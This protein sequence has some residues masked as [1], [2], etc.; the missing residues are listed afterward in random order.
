MEFLLHST[1][2]TTTKPGSATLPFGI[3]PAILDPNSGEEI[4]D[5]ECEGVLVIKDSWPGQMRTVFGDHDR[6][7]STYFNDYK[8]ITFQ[9]MGVEGIKMGITGS[10]EELMTF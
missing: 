1:R 6:F 10:L 9:V 4:S 8:V 2:N 3:E 7:V 5:E